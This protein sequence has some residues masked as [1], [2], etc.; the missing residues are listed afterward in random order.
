MMFEVSHAD[1]D[2]DVEAT[3]LAEPR[4]LIITFLYSIFSAYM[5]MNSMDSL[6]VKLDKWN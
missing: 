2:D 5:R 3:E 1:R 4:I 6:T